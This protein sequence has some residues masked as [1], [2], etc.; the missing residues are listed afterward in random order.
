MNAIRV[1]GLLGLAGVATPADAQHEGHAPPQA[2]PINSHTHHA[3]SGPVIP[4]PTDADRAAAFPDTDDMNAQGHMSAD[5]R[6]RVLAD[7][8]EWQD[9]DA[10]DA[11]AWD[12]D[13]FVGGDFNRLWLRAEGERE[14]GR[15][16]ADLQV[17]YG[18]AFAPWWE[19]VVGVR[20]DF[21]PGPSRDWAAFGI[22]GLAPYRF[23][24]EATAY[25]GESG[26]TALRL[27]AEYDLLLTNRLV[28][29]PLVQL[30][31]YGKEDPATGTGSGLS[32]MEAGLRLRYEIRRELAPYVGVAWQR[33]F[34]DTADLARAAGEEIE[35]TRLVAGLRVW[36]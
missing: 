6:W 33:R 5:A 18:H 4:Q 35:D 2:K 13:A 7:R 22:Q 23:D 10:G 30:D 31:L 26:R 34:G 11:L 27:E 12:L 32:E 19:L 25:L 24:V 16:R 21:G 3:S 36:F 9:A 8:L 15:T 29:Q 20:R 14:D 1:L 17:L 28:L